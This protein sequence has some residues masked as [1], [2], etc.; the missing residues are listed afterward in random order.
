[1]K[2]TRR[3]YSHRWPVREYDPV[4]NQGGAVKISIVFDSR[5]GTT[6]AA[7]M[8]MVKMAV[9]AGHDST[10]VSV[11]S[12]SPAEIAASDAIC[13]GSWTEG[14]F[15]ILQH[16]TKATMEFIDGLTLSGTP[17]AVFCTYKTSPGKML[18]KMA[19]ALEASGAHVS[20][21]L[22]SRGSRAPEGF[23]DWIDSLGR[24]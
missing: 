2:A 6:E 15:F 19:A 23:A 16:A 3:G 13:I 9:A 8:E 7:A 4:K 22:R 12:A 20:A 5:G 1:M 11:Q 17:A 24:D 21:R 14:L 10:A 18:D